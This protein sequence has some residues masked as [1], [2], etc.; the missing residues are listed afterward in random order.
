MI[1]HAHPTTSSASASASTRALASRPLE[2]GEARRLRD[3]IAALLRKEQ[4]AMAEFLVALADFDRRRGWE[5]LGHANLFAFLH[6]ELRLSKSA[7]FYRKSAA[8]LLQDFPEVIEPLRDGRLCLSTIAEL[9]KVLTEENRATV[10]PRFFGLSAREAQE[11]VAELQPRGVPSTRMVVTRVLRQSAPLPASVTQPLLTFG[12]AVGFAPPVSFAPEPDPQVETSPNVVPPSR[13]LTS[14]LANGGGPGV[15]TRDQIVPLTAD[16]RRIHLVVSKQVVK[17]LE[18][19]REG[20]SRSIRGA[21]VEQVLEAALDL[22]LEKQA[23]TRGQVK[24]P[25]SLASATA[26][27]PTPATPPI[28]ATPPTSSTG[29]YRQGPGRESAEMPSTA[30]HL[31]LTAPEVITA[32]PMHRRQGPREA[33]PA[34]VKRAVW[35]RDQGRCTWPLASGGR[36]DSTHLLELDHVNPW[37][38]DGRPTEAN[39]RLLCH[40]PKGSPGFTRSTPVEGGRSASPW[41]LAI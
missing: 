7:A 28:L 4:A 41:L 21:T 2:L 11:L 24:R 16:L 27:P 23:K 33:I 39:L 12:P 40:R 26:T 29:Q 8:G 19:A 5:A 38:R 35:A 18:T 30:L 34:A 31:T 37:A 6:V 9:A 1:T 36:C 13:V 32:P 3:L 17:K 22:L 15:A 25:R 20:L 10:A 14:E